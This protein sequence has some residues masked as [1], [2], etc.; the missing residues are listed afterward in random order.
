MCLSFESLETQLIKGQIN[1]LSND[2]KISLGKC[3][4]V[5]TRTHQAIFV[6]SAKKFVIISV[7]QVRPVNFFSY[8]ILSSITKLHRRRR[9]SKEQDNEKNFKCSHDYQIENL[10]ETNFVEI[11][12]RAKQILSVQCVRTLMLHHFQFEGYLYIWDLRRKL[13]ALLEPPNYASELECLYKKEKLQNDGRNKTV[14]I[15]A[16]KIPTYFGCMFFLLTF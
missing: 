4:C 1:T 6:Y 7:I 5:G 9:P 13:S 3:L 15:S 11:F 14:L 12:G 10:A 16:V 2:R 8:Q